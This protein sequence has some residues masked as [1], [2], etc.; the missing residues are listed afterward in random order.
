MPDI[1]LTTSSRRGFVT[2]SVADEWE[3][4]VDAAGE[5]GPTPNQLLLA[6]YASC[7]I[8]ALRVSAREHGIDDLGQV[9][10]DVTG[11]LNENDDLS[12]IGFDIRVEATLGDRVDDVVGYAQSICHVQSALREGLHADVS[13]DDAAL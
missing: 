3:V 1:E 4:T 7:F 8:P 6:N 13:V 11:T 9:E 2:H 10:I 12:G 5:A